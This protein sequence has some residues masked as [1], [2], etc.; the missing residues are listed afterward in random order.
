MRAQQLLVRSIAVAGLLVATLFGAAGTA[1]AH[2]VLES[3]NPADGSTVAT[4]PDQ[5]T[6]TFNKNVLALGSVLKVTGPDGSVTQGKP[7]VTDNKVQQAIAPGSAAGDYS[8]VWRVT[9][10][11]GH[12]I[13]G[14][15]AFSAK[16]GSK[17]AASAETAAPTTEAVT[18]TTSEAATPEATATDAS[19]TLGALDTT[20]AETQ[21]SGTS[22]ALI[23]LLIAF[24]AAVLAA[25]IYLASRR[26]RPSQD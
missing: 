3:S 22:S 12:P 21:D 9:S 23:W 26:T 11:D 6:L 1:S 16:A 2:D 25:G 18:P 7:T 20:A 17:A 14:E 4:L 5:I 24:V 15:F 13:S 19:P 8:V 10:A